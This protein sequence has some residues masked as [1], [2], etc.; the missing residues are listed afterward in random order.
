MRLSGCT[1]HVWFVGRFCC[2]VNFGSQRVT[3][4]K[5]TLRVGFILFNSDVRN[6]LY[7]ASQVDIASVPSRN[8]SSFLHSLRTA[9]PHGPPTAT[10]GASLPVAS[11]Q[12]CGRW[13]ALWLRARLSGTPRS[14]RG[15]RRRRRRLRRALQGLRPAAAAPCS[16][17]DA[18]T[19]TATKEL[20]SI[21]A[22]LLCLVYSQ[23]GSARRTASRSYSLLGIPC[24]EIKI[25]I[26]TRY[27]FA[28]VLR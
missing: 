25:N 5:D 6:F 1:Q 3:N 23:A 14:D 15:W 21:T 19:D 13:A 22:V 9:L 27:R 18:P 4:Q 12:R 28:F 24:G 10:T 16:E 7:V 11:V 26:Y 8:R 20:R 17:L 2:A